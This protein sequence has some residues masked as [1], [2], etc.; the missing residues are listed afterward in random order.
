MALPVKIASCFGVLKFWR[1]RNYKLQI[2]NIKQITMTKIRNPKPVLVIEYWN[3]IF[4]DAPPLLQAA[5]RA[6][7]P[8]KPLRGQLKAGSLGARIL[9]F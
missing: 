5:A 7:R 3:L 9:Y 2:T 8:L 6:E 4:C 1:I